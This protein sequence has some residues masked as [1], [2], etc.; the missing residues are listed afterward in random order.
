MDK[1]YSLC[2]KIISVSVLIILLVVNFNVNIE[3]PLIDSNFGISFSEAEARTEWENMELKTE[4]CWATGE[5]FEICRT[6]SETC[7]DTA[8]GTCSNTD[9]GEN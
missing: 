2:I 4:T 3:S 5:E 9:P 8:Q 6:A 1:L 7:K